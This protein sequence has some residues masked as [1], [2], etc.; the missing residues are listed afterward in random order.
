MSGVRL[1]GS[2]NFR[3]RLVCATLAGKALRLSD[4]RAEANPPGLPILQSPLL[5]AA[6]EGVQ[7]VRRRNH[8]R[9]VLFLHMV[10][11]NGA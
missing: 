3:Y 4:I 7:R 11:S 8:A 6:G 9:Q 2:A 5:P 1:Q 10:P